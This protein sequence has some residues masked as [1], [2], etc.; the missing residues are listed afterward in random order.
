MRITGLQ[1]QIRSLAA[2]TIPRADVQVS[3]TWQNNPGIA[4][5]AL[6]NVPNA[7]VA[8]LLGHNLAGGAANLPVNLVNYML[9]T[10]GANMPVSVT[11]DRLNQIDFRV[12]KILKFGRT[13]TLLGVDVFNVTNSSALKAANSTYGAT[14]P[15][16]TQILQA[17]FLKLS[18]QFDF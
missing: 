13:R 16:P 1:T 17:R 4:L 14:W 6:D 10:G 7:V 2:F 15:V 8:P 18:A 3:A 11:A 5:L 9:P 12:A